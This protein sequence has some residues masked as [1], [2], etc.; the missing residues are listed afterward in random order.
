MFKWFHHSVSHATRVQRIE[1]GALLIG[2][3][4]AYAYSGGS[5]WMY[6]L[7]F[8]LPD[9]FMLGYIAGPRIGAYVYNLGHSLA[10]PLTISTIGIIMDAQLPQLIAQIWLAHVGLDRL[11]GYGLKE[12]SHFRDTHLG[13]VGHH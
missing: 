13:R 1:A 6:G 11:L 5:W 7:L 9:A 8:F 3:T 4:I 2:I 10:V 12:T